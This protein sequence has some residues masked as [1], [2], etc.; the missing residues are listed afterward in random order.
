[1]ADGTVPPPQVDRLHALG[2]WLA[3][4]GQAIFG[5]TRPWT[6]AEGTTGDGT[7]VRFTASRD[8]SHVHAAVLG[9]LSLG[10]ITLVGVGPAAGGVRLL[11]SADASRRRST[12]PTSTSSCPGHL[13]LNR[14]PCS[15]W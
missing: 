11:G 2:A 5:G 3:V 6:R 12:D 4:N 8:G 13:A 7:P 1:M 10:E 15:S 14:Y 9:P